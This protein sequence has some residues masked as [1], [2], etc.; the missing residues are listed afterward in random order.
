VI[1]AGRLLL[2][3]RADFPG[4]GDVLEQLMRRGRAGAVSFMESRRIRRVVADGQSICS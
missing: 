2:R 3:C 4:A 1:A